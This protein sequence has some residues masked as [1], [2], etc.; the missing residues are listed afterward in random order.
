MK[1]GVL[2]ILLLFVSFSFAFAQSRTVTGTVLDETGAGKPGVAVS[3]KG[4]QVGTVTDPDGK[5]ELELPDNIATLVFRAVGYNTAERAINADE[6]N[7]TMAIAATEIEGIVVTANAVRREKRSVGY[8]TSSVTGNELTQGGNTSPLNALTGKVAGANINTTSNSPGSSSR[9]VLRGGTS[10]TGNNQALLVVDG[11]PMLNNGPGTSAVSGVG[12]LSNQVDYGSRGND[13]NPD[14]IE[15]ITVLKGPAATAQYGSLGANGAIMIT[16]KKGRKTTGPSKTDIE[17]S[18]SYELSNILK[19]PEFQDTYGQGNIYEGIYDDRRENFSWG[20]KFN[21]EMRPWGQIIDGKQKVKPYSALPNN[22]KDFFDV[23]QTWNN[24][25]SIGGGTDVSTYRV[26][27]GSTNSKLIFPGN[28]YNRYT[29]GFNG[30]TKLSNKLYSSINFNYTK[31]NSEMPGTGQGNASVMDNLFQGP[32]DIP[33]SELKDLNDKYNSMNYVDSTGIQRYGYYGAYA[34]NPYFTLNNYKNENRVDHVYGNV[35]VGYQPFEWLKIEDRI[36]ADVIADRRFQSVPKYS[37]EP[38]DPLYAGLPHVEVGRYAQDIYNTDNLFNDLMATF[39]KDIAK[40]LNLNVLAGFN[41]SQFRVENLYSSTNEEGGLI[42]PDYYNVSNTNGPALTR[43]SLSLKRKTA[44]YADAVAGYKNMLFLE[45]TGR[46]DASST[47]EKDR[48]YFYYSTNASFVFTELIK[49]NFKDKVWNYGKFRIAYGSTANDADPYLTQTIY[50]TSNPSGNF[51]SNRFP[52]GGV[53][54]AFTYGNTIGYPDLRQE[55]T[56]EFEVGLENAF[57]KGRITMDLSVYNRK[58]KDQ[59]VSVPIATSAGFSNQVLNVGLSTNTGVELALRVTPIRTKSG[60]K[61]DIYGTYTR[62]KSTVNEIYPGTDQIIIP[63]S[64]VGMSVVAAVG[65]PF[66]TFYTTGFNYVNGNQVIV[67]SAS[68]LPKVSTSAQYYGSYNPDYQASW[69]TALS[70]KGFSLNV[71]FDTKQGGLFYSRTRDVMS[72][73]GTSKETENREEQ[74]W[75][76]SVYLGTDGQYHT[77]TT[78]YSPYTYFTSA[79]QRPESENLVNATY[80]KLREASISYMFPAKWFKK[81]YVGGASVSLYGNNLAIWTPKSNRY[82]D[83]E[84]N[85]AG[86]SNLQGFDFSAQPSLRRYGINV[87]FTF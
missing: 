46:Q 25:I 28:K 6:I 57:W 45:L 20:E 84:I 4:T 81:T 69:G 19:Y 2:L 18:S 8:S 34:L 30:S 61:W 64:P 48:S 50:T 52:F 43:N 72:F 79:G 1:K 41:Y 24:N 39:N 78:Q 17:V 10:L 65:K 49:G 85:S 73:V 13:I 37:S 59:I 32:R 55:Y 58:S 15:S 63:G 71:L 38:V 44:I 67:D 29:V 33:I 42:T 83:P 36:A 70:Y 9:I 76:N 86:S 47:I 82:V 31:I 7:V 80:V 60:F 35:I 74:I 62:N 12:A 26:S 3:G 87:K 75:P 14:D 77:N 53:G 40:D 21:G 27:L 11:V 5:Y 22:V 56:N 66:G 54:G 51:G 68:G 23:G 16:T